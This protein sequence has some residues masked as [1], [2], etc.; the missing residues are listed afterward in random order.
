MNDTE[1]ICLGSSSAGN[2]Y[3][4]RYNGQVVLVEVGFDIKTIYK[5]LLENN[6]SVDD[7]VAVVA[8]HKH[9]DHSRSLEYFA[10]HGV[11]CFAPADCF[12]SLNLSEYP[13]ITPVADGS[14]M[15]VCDWLKARAFSV[16]H[17]PDVIAL[18]YIFFNTESDES[19]LFINDTRCFEFPFTQVRFD[20]IFVECNHIRKQLEAILQRALDN[21]KSGEAFKYR[22]QAECHL[23]L[24][25]C[26]KLLS[27]ITTL[28]GYTKGIF[29]MHLSRECCNDEVV[30]LEIKETFG[31]PTFVCHKDG[32]I[33]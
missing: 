1:F 13:N 11:R 9:S 24:A 22:R 32:G 2:C 6:I 5:K 3:A 19:I 17:D 28:K 18:G 10:T 31:V 30:K 20:Y 16:C 23:S 4:F 21:G 25:G 29:L 8:T 33:M 7:I 15:K 12:G 26:K 27:L 14:N